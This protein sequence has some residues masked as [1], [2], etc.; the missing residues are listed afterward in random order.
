VGVWGAWVFEQRD[1]RSDYDQ[2]RS[3]AEYRQGFGCHCQTPRC[4]PS[5]TAATPS[6][7][8]GRVGWMSGC[9]SGCVGDWVKGNPA[10]K[11]FSRQLLCTVTMHLGILQDRVCVCICTAQPDLG[12]PPLG[13]VAFFGPM[14]PRYQQQQHNPP[15]PLVPAPVPAAAP[16]LPSTSPG[17][18]LGQS[19][20]G[21]CTPPHL[22]RQSCGGPGSRGTSPSC[23]QSGAG[24]GACTHLY[25][26]DIPTCVPG[27]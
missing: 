4:T 11:A 9:V 8:E 7:G 22:Q 24:C 13:V 27:V 2:V 23:A 5:P 21:S 16:V 26:G 17:T 10:S 12:Q 25:A 18:L 19:C 6:A 1:T 3:R 20:T 15:P 14:S